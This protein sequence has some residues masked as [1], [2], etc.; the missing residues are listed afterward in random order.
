MILF[1]DRKKSNLASLRPRDRGIGVK[2]NLASLARR[3][4]TIGELINAGGDMNAMDRFECCPLNYAKMYPKSASYL[5]KKE[6]NARDVVPVYGKAIEEIMERCNKGPEGEVM[7]FKEVVELI[8][9]E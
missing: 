4:R 5:E 1:Y 6:V 8:E 2:S 9:K 7:S 3:I